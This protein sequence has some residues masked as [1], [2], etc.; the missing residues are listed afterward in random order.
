MGVKAPT[1]G[2]PP[3]PVLEALQIAPAPKRRGRPPGGGSRATFTPKGNPKFEDAKPS[4]PKYRNFMKRSATPR[5]NT[6]ITLDPAII[7]SVKNAMRE[8]RKPQSAI[9]TE[10]L[11]A[12][13]VEVSTN[14]GAL[15]EFKGRCP[16]CNR[17]FKTQR[18]HGSK[19][20]LRLSIVLTEPDVAALDYIADGW[21]GGTYSRALEAA[22][23]FYLPEWLLPPGS[24]ERL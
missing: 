21:F 8:L 9:I 1:P 11:R 18:P 19:R 10:S 22:I 20:R 4:E 7:R 3:A 14:P 12:L 17:L 16:A 6:D 5:K 15:T 23:I 24:K 13:F 2:K